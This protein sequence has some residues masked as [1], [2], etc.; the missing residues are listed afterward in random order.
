[1]DDSTNRWGHE[2]SK[3]EKAQQDMERQATFY[4]G[5]VLFAVKRGVERMIQNVGMELDQGE[6]YNDA[7]PIRFSEPMDEA[8]HPDRFADHLRELIMLPSEQEGIE[9]PLDDE[10]AIDIREEV[11]RRWVGD[12]SQP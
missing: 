7:L 1:M 6:F 8:L 11:I 2:L 5:R 10:Y 3:V 12:L 4:V 9:D